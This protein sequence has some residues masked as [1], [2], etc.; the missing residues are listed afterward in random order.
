MYSSVSQRARLLASLFA[1]LCLLAPLRAQEP[2]P[3]PPPPSQETEDV[4]RVS[5][6]LVQTDV[7]VFGKDGAFVDGL[8][9]EEF[10][11][12]V[13]GKPQPIAFFERVEAGAVNEDAQLA[14]A[15]GGARAP[16][17]PDGAPVPLDRGRTLIF[18]VDDLHLSTASALRTRQALLR[19]FDEELRQNDEA[20]VASASGQ[21][22]FLQQFTDD[23]AVLRAAANRIQPRAYSLSD[24]QSP[25]M[26]EM[27]ALAINRN[28]FNV[29]SYFVDAML[30]E[31]PLLSREAAENNVRSRGREI[32]RRSSQIT[33]TMLLSLESLVRYS[34]PLPG[35]KILFFISD[36][37]L[38]EQDEDSTRERLRRITDAAARAGVVIYS[39]DPSG[40]RSGLPDAS[41]D[42]AFDVS[43]RLASAE[44]GEIRSRQEP[45]HT[46]A[47]DTGGRALV[48]TNAMGAA[49]EGALKETAR[50]Y[51]LAWRPEGEA[52]RGA[53]K[54]RRIEVSVRG[55]RDLN[56][57]VRRGFYVG[58]AP[59]AETG[60]GRDGGKRRKNE[61]AKASSQTA[62]ESVAD[63]E[64][65]TAIGAARPLTALP[66]SLSV[67]YVEVAG[68]GAV[69]T[70]SVGLEP[71]ALGLL[72]KQ[73]D[74]RSQIDVAAVIYDESGKYVTSFRQGLTVVPPKEAAEPR[75]LIVQSQQVKLNPGLYQVRAAVR[76]QQT[77]R[78]GSASEWVEIP[79]FKQ[80]Q[81]ALSSIFLAE[82]TTG[83]APEKLK[84][85]QLSEGVVLNVGRRFSRTSWMRFVTF[86]Y[87]AKPGA[88][89]PDV[90]LQ[91]QVFRDDQPVL[92]APLA[93]VN[94]ADAPDAAR[95]PYAAEIPLG[96]FPPGRYVLQLTAI[97]RT[98]KN[99]AKRRIDFT[100]E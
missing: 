50:Y 12:K 8:K 84:P 60:G 72:G 46:L 79:N 20:A 52:A 30:R 44:M 85:E 80:G 99:Q 7:M 55:R 76:D 26:S 71:E 89:R 33:T 81:F 91:V 40:L 66:A 95:L 45:L 51:L 96:S 67:G 39:M 63:R 32:M 22:G 43:G 94:S 93:R 13:D 56:V 23:R 9:A 25:P 15:R 3:T 74:G 83:D 98:A 14:A 28:D 57:M 35:R 54:F 42:V 38:V 75:E 5:S 92:T 61:D 24:G 4:I 10:E 77:R 100:I 21:V 37:F 62:S 65:R 31:N 49:V 47:A 2:P 70:V 73:P 29:I 90:A 53:A 82:R 64:L 48:N 41:T 18:F 36:G 1:G 19:F 78:A 58:D 97:D 87:N 27:H 16:S 68:H 86:I 88:P 17:R 69:A 6:E 34:A 59:P 11:L